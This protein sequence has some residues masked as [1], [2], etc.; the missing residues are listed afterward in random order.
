M[1]A[2]GGLSLYSGQAAQGALHDERRTD[3]SGKRPNILLI[4]ADD[5]GYGDISCFRGGSPWISVVP[6]Q[7]D[8][9]ISTPCIDRLA[10][11]GVSFTDFH[12][13]DAVCSPTRASLL[14]G[15]YNQRT[16][17]CNVLGQLGNAMVKVAKPGEIPF[18]GLRPEEMTVAEIL[19]DNGY[20]TGC[21]GKWHL[22]PMETHHPLLNGFDE[23][24]G[25]EGS[26]G[27]NFSM[28]QKGKSYF[29][30]GRTTAKA[31]GGW[32][33]DVLADEAVRF[34]QKNDDAPFFAYV[35][36]TAPHLP[37]VGPNDKAIA[38]AWDEKGDSPRSDLY[39]AYKD[40]VEG[41]DKAVGRIIDALKRSDLF[42]NTL[43]LF[44]S[45]NGPVDHGSPGG[46]SGRKTNLFEAGTR[47]PT[48][49][50]WQGKIKAGTVCREPAMS[51]DL[52]STICG[53]ANIMVPAQ[54]LADGVDLCPV[55]TQSKGM[56]RR[57]LFWERPAGVSM[58][59]FHIRRAAVRDGRWKLLQDRSGTPFRLFDLSA[60]PREE[61]D[62]ASSMPE[63][64]TQ[65]RSAFEEW[66]KRVYADAPWD[67]DEY[68]DRF[69]KAGILVREKH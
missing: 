49:A 28:E 10:G 54:V 56:E 36:F 7:N 39:R 60:D 50:C 24:V 38:D 3:H 19:K 22:G 46:F 21:F 45:D 35:P 68:L 58:K 20:R 53:A 67:Y 63:K 23:F 55:L 43:I 61:H 44:S 29:Y 2:A 69:E 11:E 59:N 30:R 64:V 66:K 32:F 37:Y 6:G 14:T 31:P 42:E 33:T 13:N 51:M 16:G 1:L 25:V 47:V 18:T 4:L 26:A 12:S 57:L 27:D 48:I 8:I 52:F 40:V 41:M 34:M 9:T 65:L 17:V 15:K 5:L 62:L